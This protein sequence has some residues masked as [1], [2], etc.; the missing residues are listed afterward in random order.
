MLDKLQEKNVKCCF[1]QREQL[2][3]SIPIKWRKTLKDDKHKRKDRPYSKDILIKVKNRM[4][5]IQYIIT[6]DIYWEL[7]NK[8]SGKIPAQQKWEELHDVE[9]WENIYKISYR[10]TRSTKLQTFQYKIL[11]RQ[12]CVYSNVMYTIVNYMSFMWK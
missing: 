10:C 11:N 7:V 5:D 2:K 1:L 3:N 9:N 8:K 12:Y 6:K 4:Q